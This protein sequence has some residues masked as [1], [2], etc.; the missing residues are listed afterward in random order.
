MAYCVSAF[1][2]PGGAKSV[3]RS[4][5]VGRVYGSQGHLF[6]VLDV[7]VPCSC[8]IVAIVVSV[9]RCTPREPRCHSR[10]LAVNV[11]YGFLFASLLS[12][13]LFNTLLRITRL[14]C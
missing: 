11:N 14:G 1:V 5:A 8:Y 6:A 9:R 2:H 13:L 10:R 7:G 4:V 3:L 12:N